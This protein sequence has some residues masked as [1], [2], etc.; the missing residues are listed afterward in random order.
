MADRR[1]AAAACKPPSR[2]LRED[3]VGLSGSAVATCG[4]AKASAA[5]GL[6]PVADTQSLCVGSYGI[7]RLAIARQPAVT[8][9][10][11]PY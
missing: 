5:D 3:L 4:A 10:T 1:A 9:T 6:G 11:D 8:L 7:R 2:S